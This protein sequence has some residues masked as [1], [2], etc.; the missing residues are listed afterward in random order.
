MEELLR[1]VFDEKQGGDDAKDSKHLRLVFR[2]IVHLTRPVSMAVGS[3]RCAC[4]LAQ[5]LR[6]Q[7]S[8]SFAV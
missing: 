5:E 6:M 2:E 8:R 7:R 4:Q 1:S 3:G